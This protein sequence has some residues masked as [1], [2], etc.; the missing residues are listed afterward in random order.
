MADVKKNNY[1]SDKKMEEK[2]GKMDTIKIIE[3]RRSKEVG[4]DEKF[5]ILENKR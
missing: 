3:Y 4:D 2:S 5:D 1:E